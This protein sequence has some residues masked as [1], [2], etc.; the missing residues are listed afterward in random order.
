[1]ARAAV[2]AILFELQ[3]LFDRLLILLRLMR[4]ALA[5][6]AF[7]LDKCFLGHNGL[8]GDKVEHRDPVCRTLP[9]GLHRRSH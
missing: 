2:L 7:E 5:R 8:F 6:R 9:R 4:H 3:T 1:M